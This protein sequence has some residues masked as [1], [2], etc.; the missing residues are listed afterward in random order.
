MAAVSCDPTPL[1]PQIIGGMGELLRLAVILLD[2][3]LAMPWPPRPLAKEPLTM[4]EAVR[5]GAAPRLGGESAI[6]IA[7]G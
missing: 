5:P 7:D 4:G 2:I 1:C 6:L 3:C